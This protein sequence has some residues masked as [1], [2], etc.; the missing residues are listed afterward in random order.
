MPDW[1]EKQYF[2]QFTGGIS[3]ADPDGDGMSN[4]DEFL[5]ATS[6]VDAASTLKAT[7]GV[8]APATGHFT[9]QWQSVP[10]KTYRVSYADN[11]SGTWLTDLPASLVTTLPGETLSSYTDTTSG[12]AGRRFYRVEVVI[13]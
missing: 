6:P 13:P 7:S 1:W 3:T 5:A 10:G 4:R 11:L 8:R 2:N 9:I 12:S